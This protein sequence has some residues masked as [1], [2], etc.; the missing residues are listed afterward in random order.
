VNQNQNHINT[1][2]KQT[3]R[4]TRILKTKL[5]AGNKLQ[6]HNKVKEGFC[7]AERMDPNYVPKASV[8]EQ[9]GQVG[10]VADVPT[11]T[12]VPDLSRIVHYHKI[13]SAQITGG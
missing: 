7:F 4:H 6:F 13:L 12:T 11:N 3:I 9:E 2:V 10:F 5:K 1:E 8:Y